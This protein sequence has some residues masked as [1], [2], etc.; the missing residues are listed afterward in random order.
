MKKSDLLFYVLDEFAMAV[1]SGNFQ[2][3]RRALFGE[4][5][6]DMEQTDAAGKTL[7]MS[8]VCHGEIC[9]F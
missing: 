5:Q 6:Y 3:V 1:M 9:F 8:A 2:C 4:G 7:L